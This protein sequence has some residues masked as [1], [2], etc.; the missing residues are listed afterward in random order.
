MN[1]KYEQNNEYRDGYTLT[2]EQSEE[3]SE[4]QNEEQNEEQSDNIIYVI[5]VNGI[6]KCFSNTTKEVDTMINYIIY[7]LKY[8]YFTE[9]WNNIECISRDNKILWKVLN[10]NRIVAYI[11]GNK[12]NLL[13]FYEQILGEI[14]IE[15]IKK[16]N[17]NKNV[18]TL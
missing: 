9:G 15:I 5:K 3:Q 17:N 1:I 12:Y 8:K 14:E 7:K 2:E 11:T 4:E 13:V 18:L 10:S 6:T 16:Y